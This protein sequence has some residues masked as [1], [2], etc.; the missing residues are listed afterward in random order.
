MSGPSEMPVSPVRLTSFL[1]KIASRCNL[2]CDY[3]YVYEH[4]DQTWRGQPTIMSD[5]IVAALARRVA[6]YAGQECLR[7]ICIVFHGG[8]PLL[9]GASRLVDAARRIRDA[10][11]PQTTIRF[12]LQTNGTLL[13]EDALGVLASAHVR[14]REQSYRSDFLLRKEEATP[15]LKRF[16]C[17]LCSSQPAHMRSRRM[18]FLKATFEAAC[19]P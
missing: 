6:E 16:V 11:P 18:K 13:D 12:S 14:S 10:V 17:S 1:V 15:C 2:A 4:A 7:A 5:P 19:W 9:A 3:C 8:E